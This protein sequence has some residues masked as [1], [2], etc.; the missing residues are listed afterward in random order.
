MRPTRSWRPGEEIV[1][2][3][4]IL[5]PETL[6]AG[7][8]RLAVGLYD[9]ATGQRLAVSAGPASFAIELGPVRVKE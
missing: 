3:Y 8:Y 4:G 7:E 1:D 5:L 9:P 2:R 6:G